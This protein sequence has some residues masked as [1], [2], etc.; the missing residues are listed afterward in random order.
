MAHRNG[1]ALLGL[2][3]AATLGLVLV[4]P[5]RATNTVYTWQG[6]GNA[7]DQSANWL[8]N[9]G[10]PGTG[11]ETGDTASFTSVGEAQYNV[12]LG[13]SGDRAVDFIVLQGAGASYTIGSTAFSTLTIYQKVT[14][15]G[16]NSFITCKV[17][18]GAVNDLQLDALLGTL[19]ISGAISGAKGITKTGTG[20]VLLSGANN[21]YAGLTSVNAGTLKLGSTS[22]LGATAGATTVAAGGTLDLNGFTLTTADTLT[23]AGTGVGGAGALVNTGAVATYGAAVTI[24]TGGATIGGTGNITLSSPLVG[25]NTPLT[26]VG[27]NTLILG[28]TSARTG[29]A[30]INGGAIRLGAA[31]ALGLVAININSGGTLQVNHTTTLP[32]GTGRT[33]ALNDGGTIQAM[34]SVAIGTLITVGSTAGTSVTFKADSGATLYLSNG[35]NNRVTGGV[36]TAKLNIEGPG[37]VQIGEAGQA[38]TLNVKGNW[39]LKPQGTL[40]IRADGQ[41]GL[42]AD[43]NDVY[44]QGG[45]LMIADANT[46]ADASRVLDFSDLLGGT[47]NCNGFYLTFPSADNQLVGSGP[48]TKIGSGRL[49]IPRANTTFSGPVTVTGTS[50]LEIRNANSLGSATKSTIALGGTA[51]TLK[52]Q[53]D[54]ASTDFGNVV[55][56]TGN[57]TITSEMITTAGSGITNTL[58][59]LN[60]SGQTLTVGGT[61]GYT[62][63]VS[64]TTAL[65]G[66]NTFAVNTAGID[67]ALNGPVTGTTALIKSGAGTMILTNAANDYSGPTTLTLGALRANVGAG[68]SPNTNLILGGGVLEGS[69]A[70]AI[71]PVLGGSAGQVQWSSAAGGGFSANGGKVTVNIGG[72][73]TPDTL[74]WGT[75]VYFVAGT[76]SLIFGSATANNEVEFLNPLNLGGAPRTVTVNAG[77]GGDFATLS[78]VLS[79]GSL[80]K[81]GAGTLVLTNSNAYTGGTTVSAGKLI[82]TAANPDLTGTTTVSGGTLEM[83]HASALVASPVVL[84]GTGV[85]NLNAAGCQLVSVTAAP[86]GTVNLNVAGSLAADLSCSGQINYNVNNAGGNRTITIAGANLQTDVGVLTV[87][88]GVTTLGDGGTGTDVLAVNGGNI[89]V[90]NSATVPLLDRTP[91]TGNLTLKP[92]AILSEPAAGGLNAAKIANLG[93]AN[94][95]FRGLAADFAADTITVATSGAGTPYRGLSTDRTSRTLLTGTVTV[96]TV[97]GNTGAILQGIFAQTLIIGNGTTAGCV[98]IMPN[99][100]DTTA[101]ITTYGKVRLDDDAAVFGDSAAGKA[102]VFRV[103]NGSQLYLNQNTAMGS[104]TGIAGIVVESG[105]TLDPANVVGAAMMNG[106]VSLLSGGILLLND[107]SGHLNGTGTIT[108]EAGAITSIATNANVL[109][110]LGAGTALA[111]QSLGT[112]PGSIVRVGIASVPFLDAAVHDAA[113]FVLSSGTQ[114]PTFGAGLTL[115]ASGGVGG[116]LTN[117]GA[118]RTYACTTG[119]TV[120][121][122]GATFAGTTVGTTGFTLTVT[123]TVNAAGN[124]VTIGSTTPIDGQAKAGNVLFNNPFQAGSV[125]VVGG[126]GG[127]FDNATTNVSGD[128]HVGGVGS[129][130]Y[131]GSGGPSA[132]AGNLS[133]RLTTT[134]L[135]IADRVADKI[136]IDN[137][138]R[139]EMGLKLTTPVGPSGRIE[140]TQ[141]FIITGDVNPTSKRSFWVSR[142]GATS[143]TPAATLMD[144]TI[145]PGGV[146]AVDENNVNVRAYLKLNG[147][148][149]I[150]QFDAINYDDITNVTS[151]H[152][153]VTLTFGRVGDTAPVSTI[154]GT[155]GTDININVV[156]GQMLLRKGA[157]MTG[158]TI[159]IT[160]GTVDL[161]SALRVGGS[162]PL[163]TGFQITLNGGAAK[164]NGRV[165]AVL[166]TGDPPLATYDAAIRIEAGG[167]GLGVA[168]ETTVDDAT[169]KSVGVTYFPNVTV[170][171]GA[172]VK[173]YKTSLNQEAV[174]A[175]LKL[176][177]NAF[178]LNSGSG[179]PTI[180]DITGIGGSAADHTL[181][182][183]TTGD[184][185]NT[186]VGSL[187]NAN[188]VYANAHANNK[189]LSLNAMTAGAGAYNNYFQ[190]NDNK[191]SVLG[192]DYIQANVDPGAGTLEALDDGRIYLMCNT[193][194]GLPPWGDNLAVN[195]GGTSR[196]VG[197]VEADPL[198]VSGDPRSGAGQFNG[199][200]TINDNTWLVSSRTGSAYTVGCQYTFN[201]VQVADGATVTLDQDN[202]RMVANFNQQGGAAGF[203]RVNDD[204]DVCYGGIQGSGSITIQAPVSGNRAQNLVG[205]IQTGTTMEI[206]DGTSTSGYF[207]RGPSGDWTGAPGFELDGGTLQITRTGTATFAQVAWDTQIGNASNIG[208]IIIGKDGVT[209]TGGLEVHH[210]DDGVET[211]F[212]PNVG[213][214]LHYGGALRGY[215]MQGVDTAITQVINAPITVNNLDDDRT[216]VDGIL[217]SSKSSAAGQGTLIGTVQFQN[218]T[219]LD[220]S[221]VRADAG[222]G[223]A[224][225]IGG[226]GGSLLVDSGTAYLVNNA[227]DTLVTVENID[228]VGTTL[229]LAG[230]NLTQIKGTVLGYGLQIGEGWATPGPPPSDPL[231]GRALILPTADLSGLG[232]GGVDVWANGDLR[233]NVAFN[234]MLTVREAGWAYAYQAFN[235]GTLVLEK[236]S[237]LA[238]LA[239]ATFPAG[240]TTAA[241]LYIGKL[242]FTGTLVLNTGAGDPAKIGVYGADAS[243]N[244]P[245]AGGA[246]GA[247]TV[248]FLDGATA[249]Y[250]GSILAL[251]DGVDPDTKVMLAD[252]AGTDATT[253]AVVIDRNMLILNKNTYSGG[254]TIDSSGTAGTSGAND[255]T[256]VVAHKNGLGTGNVTLQATNGPPALKTTL[257]LCAADFALDALGNSRIIVNERTDLRINQDTDVKIELAGGTLTA[258]GDVTLGGTIAL[259]VGDQMFNPGDNKLTI[260]NAVSLGGGGEARIWDVRTGPEKKGRVVFS[261][262]VSGGSGTERLTVK[263]PGTLD[264][265][266]G[267]SKLST[268]NVGDGSSGGVVVT[269][270]PL[271]AA[272][273]VTVWTAH[274]YSVTQ[275]NHGYGEVDMAGSSGVIALSADVAT[276]AGITYNFDNGDFTSVSTLAL[277]ALPDLDTGAMTARTF[278]GTL[279]PDL[280]KILKEGAAAGG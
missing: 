215:V 232:A 248:K 228:G 244:D 34:Q 45:T 107:I 130:L 225:L 273:S 51:V 183:N 202:A 140:V 179:T 210:G 85:L 76:Q 147:N 250:A 9:T 261:G 125:N 153:P 86:T 163:P 234:E 255:N 28:A 258:T 111:P 194:P 178:W 262:L 181:T 53:N 22:A 240:L 268:L 218:V 123:A 148:A 32:N 69:G 223:Q 165:N 56:L 64:G 182:I 73:A 142:C 101:T 185:G 219:L 35:G 18:T 184:Y 143:A 233:L 171:D 27:S 212:G 230:L 229:V 167:G 276:A 44:F 16:T 160:G 131:L 274:A 24:G 13:A 173:G 20:E 269:G 57:A 217:A 265:S 238:L 62:L 157:G 41:L 115:D 8:P 270:S 195:L 211:A 4:T 79:N 122:G 67:L 2:L 17:A 205:I 191:V 25:T 100:S 277:G 98:T 137:G 256:V 5:A 156:A 197:R 89:L 189:T 11:G 207:M 188:I 280:G 120:G 42:V 241:N 3:V 7:W 141:P 33:I 132:D 278:Q 251:G 237:N 200:V 154:Y 133:T 121:A 221:R 74:T 59:G 113:I 168:Q 96:D 222:G 149:T 249:A 164:L 136:Y 105:G 55:T 39:Y 6:I 150:T 135:L 216:K 161:H 247:A 66:T 139:V 70:V 227:S 206:D 174:V 196:L 213:I 14:Q 36:A 60:M 260:S 52:L 108:Q 243:I 21:T 158:D 254:T 144:V 58:G 1:L 29:A 92:G 201:N 114:N 119:V 90:I 204:A 169:G 46:T 48:L 43:G 257:S 126:G 259:G 127:A 129:K 231:P 82:L 77:T 23:I 81:A 118:A 88:G 192:T 242:N 151:S 95:L 61:V 38:R 84:T 12:D 50:T 47:I 155:I 110:S 102:V 112:V 10:Y 87:A 26:K 253:T 279:K 83:Q 71:D 264:L 80:A 159:N 104:G 175:D 186:L 203:A 65:S 275:T 220:G 124:P 235:P 245:I 78:G 176:E 68:L 198:A 271:T 138:G 91:T 166:G 266:G 145:Q 172:Q 49:V 128:I 63:A 15:N 187:T 267:L 103:A 224:V 236:D 106:P 239:D 193:A 263:G 40:R 93:T 209:A 252:L 30:T 170:A 37:T 152:V 117:D 226:P 162:S 54:T 99:T 177:G 72:N 75:T 31:D 208:H 94:D 109:T 272:D 116:V 19:T 134:S 199:R 146:F 190:L 180:G 246:A 214:T 97:A